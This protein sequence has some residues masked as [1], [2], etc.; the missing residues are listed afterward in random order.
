MMRPDSRRFYTWTY[1]TPCCQDPSL[2]LSW[3]AVACT[4]TALLPPVLR[5]SASSAG[6]SA[7]IITKLYIIPDAFRLVYIGTVYRIPV[8]LNRCIQITSRAPATIIPNTV[9][10]SHI[11]TSDI[12]I[13]LYLV[14]NHSV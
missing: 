12:T 1:H 8:L 2:A 14:F 10:F 6:E 5:P 9:T 11:A 3:S 7:L 13:I 4:C